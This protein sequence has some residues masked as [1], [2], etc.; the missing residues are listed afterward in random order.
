MGTVAPKK[1]EWLWEGVVPLGCLSVWFGDGDVGKST[2]IYEFA[3]RLS[4]GQPMP[5]ETAKHEPYSSI[6][7][8]TEDDT[9]STI[10]TRLQVAGAVPCKVDVIESVA[11]AGGGD[12]Q[13]HAVKDLD[14]LEEKIDALGDCRLV[15]FDPISEYLGNVN[16]WKD[17]DLRP[18]LTP[19]KQLASR[20]RIAII[21]IA[22][23]NKKGEAPAKQRIN[24]AQ[25]LI[26]VARAGWLFLPHPDDDQ[27]TLMLKAKGN[28][29]K[30]N[31]TGF[32][33][34]LDS[35]LCGD[36]DVPRICWLDEPVTMS[37][38]EALGRQRL[39]FK[40]GEQSQALKIDEAESWLRT[41]LAGGAKAPREI[42]VLAEQQHITEPTLYRAKK[43]LGVMKNGFGE[44]ELPPATT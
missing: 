12:T 3:S 30:R 32:G 41:M 8:T 22:H 39:T 26:N 25:T 13:F 28:S 38:D 24:G 21:C 40:R 42:A 31:Q 2:T 1:Q 6:I 7:F 16:F 23:L 19:L 43:R 37:A 36:D 35:V 27:V 5:A 15:V 33:F 9:E 17:D 11:L 10:A 44:W 20:K 14:L 29:L 18:A 34:S 4:R